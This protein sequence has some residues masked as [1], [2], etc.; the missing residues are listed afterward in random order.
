MQM[1]NYES[2]GNK[3]EWEGYYNFFSANYGI[4]RGSHIGNLTDLESAF[5]R[6]I[7]FSL[8]RFFPLL[9][10]RQSNGFSITKSSRLLENNGIQKCLNGIY[11]DSEIKDENLT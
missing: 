8:I 10:K 9:L 1:P 3:L 11:L 4:L 7:P 6:Q 5:E 2:N